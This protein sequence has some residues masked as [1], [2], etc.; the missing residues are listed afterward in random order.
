MPTKKKLTEALE[1]VDLFERRGFK[2][3]TVDWNG[4]EFTVTPYLPADSEFVAH[5]VT[6][7]GT[8]PEIRLMVHRIED[9]GYA[10]EAR[11]E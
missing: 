6:I 11:D 10:D 4:V 1:L 5:S 7:R 2:D 9:A 3:T 8:L